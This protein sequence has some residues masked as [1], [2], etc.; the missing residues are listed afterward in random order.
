MSTHLEILMRV[1]LG[2]D[3]PRWLFIQTV[4]V[5][6]IWAMNKLPKLL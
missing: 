6:G 1:D 5:T 2:L 4:G 3:I